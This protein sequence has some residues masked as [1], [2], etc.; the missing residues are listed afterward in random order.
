M[1]TLRDLFGNTG[2]RADQKLKIVKYLKKKN[3]L[4][5]LKEYNK[6]IMLQ[7]M[8]WVLAQDGD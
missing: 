5:L 7:K 8:I 2:A 6:L 4:I 1:K 3:E